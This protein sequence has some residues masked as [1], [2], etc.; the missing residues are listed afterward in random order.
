MVLEEVYY[1]INAGVINAQRVPVGIRNVE[2]RVP[3]GR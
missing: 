1:L 2:L 3:N